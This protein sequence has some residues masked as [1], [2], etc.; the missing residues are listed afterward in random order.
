M[1]HWTFSKLK[2]SHTF[3]LFPLGNHTYK[4][5]ALTHGC[6]ESSRC[7]L[8][9]L[10]WGWINRV[11]F[12]GSCNP[13]QH[14]LLWRDIW[15]QEAHHLLYQSLYPVGRVWAH[16]RIDHGHPPPHWWGLGCDGGSTPTPICPAP[17][18]R[19]TWLWFLKEAFHFSPARVVIDNSYKYYSNVK[20]EAVEWISL[21]SCPQLVVDIK[22]KYW[23]YA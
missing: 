10:F 16:H 23:C 2:Y 5:F 14:S 7:L 18:Y 12:L 21:G 19:W 8:D 15:S 17:V 9:A 20:A 1:Y 4:I 13:C 11:W 22:L 6:L 3:Y